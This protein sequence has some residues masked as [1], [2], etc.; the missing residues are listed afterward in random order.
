MVSGAIDRLTTSSDTDHD[1]D[2]LSNRSESV[3]RTGK[4]SGNWGLARVLASAATVTYRLLRP[5]STWL[6]SASEPV[7]TIPAGKQGY[8]PASPRRREYSEDIYEVRSPP[9]ISK[10]GYLRIQASHHACVSFGFQTDLSAR[11]VPF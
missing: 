10:S 1:V 4:R 11:D 2:G 8:L 3:D 9:L 7:L 6:G 5:T